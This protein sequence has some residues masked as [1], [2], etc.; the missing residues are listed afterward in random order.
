MPDAFKHTIN[1]PRRFDI[2]RTRLLAQLKAGTHTGWK[3]RA[4]RNLYLSDHPLCAKCNRLGEHVHHIVPRAVAP[5]RMFD[6]SNLMTLCAE[7]HEEV[8]KEAHR[9]A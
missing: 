8:H 4:F 3:W 7:C 9:D 2:A 1:S 5:E 6:R